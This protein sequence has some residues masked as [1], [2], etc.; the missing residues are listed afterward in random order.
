LGGGASGAQPAAVTNTS[1]ANSFRMLS[2]VWISLF[3]KSLRM[4]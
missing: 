1:A 4:P 2:P 3:V